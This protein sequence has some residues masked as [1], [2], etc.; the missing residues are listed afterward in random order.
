[1]NKTIKIVFLIF[2]I[3]LS[4]FTIEAVFIRENNKELDK[5]KESIKNR[6][7]LSIIALSQNIPSDW[8]TYTNKDFGLEM[9]YPKNLEPVYRDQ[10]NM[11][12]FTEKNTSVRSQFQVTRVFPG[13]KGNIEDAIRAFQQSMKDSAPLAVP[14]TILVNGMKGLMYKDF[15]PTTSEIDLFK[16]ESGGFVSWYNIWM[17]KY[18]SYGPEKDVI[19]EK[20]L[21][22]F[23]A[24]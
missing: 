16:T 2:V 18:G 5:K 15:N 23:K 13:V 20:M 8:L 7:E 6:T 14:E 24:L 17:T 11:V 3:I 22:T 12:V 9:R 10:T 1:M 21:S 4:A 19:N